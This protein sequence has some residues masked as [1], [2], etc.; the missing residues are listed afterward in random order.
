MALTEFD[1][2]ASEIVVTRGGRLVKLIGD[3]AMF[4]AHEPAVAADIALALIEAFADHNVLP[5]VR[6]GVATGEVLARDGDFSG[7]V[8]N[9]AARA[10]KIATPSTLYADRATRDALRRVDTFTCDEEEPH[11][12]KGFAEPVRLSR[13]R[14][15]G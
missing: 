7:A 6:A 2:V 12:L 8:V 13:I 4:V 15:S 11:A 5:P 10:V 9:L 3:E 14:R 1:A